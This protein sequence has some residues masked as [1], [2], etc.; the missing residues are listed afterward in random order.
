[1]NLPLSWLI[2]RY[3]THHSRWPQFIGPRAGHGDPT[4][5]RDWPGGCL[6]LLFS[7]INLY[8]LTTI[9]LSAGSS[10]PLIR[11]SNN[12]CQ[13]ILRGLSDLIGQIEDA[14]HKSIARPHGRTSAAAPLRE[15][16]ETSVFFSRTL[17]SDERQPKGYTKCGRIHFRFLTAAYEIVWP[18]Q[19]S[20][21]HLPTDSIPSRAEFAIGAQEEKASRRIWTP[22][23]QLTVKHTNH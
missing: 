14:V 12:K 17:S 3:N 10:R 9:V 1:M 16:H 22:T 19:P 18:A 11:F 4:T 21:S 8:I 13:L 6:L 2:Y 20:P 15:P 5:P 23:S 7:Y